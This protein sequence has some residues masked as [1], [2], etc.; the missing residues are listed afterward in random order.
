M[1]LFRETP[2]DEAK[3]QAALRAIRQGFVPSQFC[4]TLDSTY[5]LHAGDLDRW[6]SENPAFAE[7]YAAAK[8]L[9]ADSLVA[10]CVVIADNPALKSDQK[11]IQIDTRMRLAAIWNSEKYSPK[12]INEHVGANGSPLSIIHRPMSELTPEERRKL[13][14]QF[15]L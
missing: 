13:E 14:K 4:G 9:G 12:V 10:E 3:A 7:A 6:A 2:Y 1:E 15:G 5:P 11:K 8:R